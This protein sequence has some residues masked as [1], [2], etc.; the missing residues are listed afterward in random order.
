MTYTTLL[1]LADDTQLERVAQRLRDVREEGMEGVETYLTAP[2][3]VQRFFDNLLF[4]LSLVAIFTLLLAGI[5]IQSALTAYLRERYTTIAIVKTL[6]ANRRFVTVN[7]YA[8]VAALGL[9]GMLL[10]LLLG[11]LLQLAMPALVRDFLPPDIELTVSVRAV[12]EGLLLGVFVVAAF[13]FIPLYRLGELKPSFIFRKSLSAC[14]S[15]GPM[16]WPWL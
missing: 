9:V 12:L 5:G 1:K 2:S 16:S 11:V 8:I 10:G 13:S 7:F 3:G 15:V 6:G 4:F 14:N